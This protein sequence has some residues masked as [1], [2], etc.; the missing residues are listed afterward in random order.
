MSTLT[1]EKATMNDAKILTEIMKK[2]FD[3]EAKKWLSEEEAYADYNIQPPGYASIEMNKYMIKE[4]NYYKVIIDEIIVGGIIVTVSGRSFGRID[5]IFIDPIYQG[6]GFGSRAISLVEKEFYDVRKWE[7]E[8]SSRQ[9]NNH[10]FYKKKG[11]EKTFET[12]DEYYY[13]KQIKIPVEEENIVENKELSRIQYDNCDMSKAEYYQ[14]N[15]KGSSFSNSNLMNSYISN[16]NL[17]H[18][19]FQNINFR[20]SLIADLNLANSEILLA[21]LGGVHFKD[22]DLG[23][24]NNPILFERCDLKGSKLSHCNLKDVEIQNSEITGMKIDN[25]LVEELLEAYYQVIK[26]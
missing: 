3:R 4:L 18:S 26:G 7:F 25:I 12:K 2:T 13:T 8:T 11:Y 15:L 20:N 19:K 6:K 14:V 9:I 1:I 5:R 16:C 10:Y 24:E 22:T 21:S 23:K 17:S